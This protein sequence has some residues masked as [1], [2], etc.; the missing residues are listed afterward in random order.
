MWIR[1]D[2]K[3][4]LLS[5]TSAMVAMVLAASTFLCSSCKERPTAPSRPRTGKEASTS[6]PTSDARPRKAGKLADPARPW[7]AGQVDVDD[8]LVRSGNAANPLTLGSVKRRD[9]GTKNARS[10]KEETSWPGLSMITRSSS[11]DEAKKYR[12]DGVYDSDAKQELIPAALTEDDKETMGDSGWLERVLKITFANKE[13][14]SMRIGKA[15][16]SPGA[17][18]SNSYVGC[19]TF[20]RRTKKKLGLS[21]LMSRDL[22]RHLKS[23]IEALLLDYELALNVLGATLA[24]ETGGLE[25]NPTGFR[26]ESD[27]RHVGSAPRLVLCLDVPVP[28][29][30]MGQMV[31]IFV[32]RLPVLHLF[33][34][35]SSERH[36]WL[37]SP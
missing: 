3:K 33:S 32:D 2:E 12:I 22:A 37:S 11:G 1:T 36:L 7:V 34:A 35:T 4:A 8:L 20:S 16:L 24:E 28:G 31:E 25:V 15:W 19:A 6:L 13:L 29:A 10:S 14:V 17:A 9:A 5:L 30:H 27:E 26:L 21:D 18:H 23:R